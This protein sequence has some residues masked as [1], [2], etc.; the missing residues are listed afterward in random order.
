[1]IFLFIFK[2]FRKKN[3]KKKQKRYKQ[4]LNFT[5]WAKSLGQCGMMI[6]PP[7]RKL[8]C[9]N[10]LQWATFIKSIGEYCILIVD[11]TMMMEI[12]HLIPRRDDQPRKKSSP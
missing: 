11:S 4:V 8:R 2:I 10:L 12:V 6:L 3:K 9:A 1:M 7:L 5:S